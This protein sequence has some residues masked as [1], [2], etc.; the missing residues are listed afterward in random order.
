MASSKDAEKAAEPKA[1]EAA[2]AAAA[3]DPE[4][5]LV[6]LSAWKQT[7]PAMRRVS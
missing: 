3:S 7:L 1:D 4:D 6:R 2:K 5:G